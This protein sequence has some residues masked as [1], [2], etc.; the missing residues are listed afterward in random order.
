MMP[1][2]ILDDVNALLLKEKGDRR[3]LEQ[4]KRAAE[5]NEAISIYE[6]NYVAKLKG[7]YLEKRPESRPRPVSSTLTQP[8][9]AP[10]PATKPAY[11][12][13][14]EPKRRKNSGRTKIIAGASGAAVLIAIL[15]I[16]ASMSGI[17]PGGA[18]PA[19]PVSGDLVSIDAGSYALGDIISI[20]GR[21]DSSLGGQVALS[22]ENPDSDLVWTENVSMKSDGA[23]S[24]LAIAGGTGWDDSGTY[25]LVL[26]HGDQTENLEFTFRG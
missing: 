6:R 9:E 25:T 2:T 3:I 14:H 10:R 5:H 1:D 21:S 4:I 12:L 19:T 13:L 20:S 22:I 24:T 7:E 8:S 16:G 11:A 15:A 26:E 23:F 18:G 17:E